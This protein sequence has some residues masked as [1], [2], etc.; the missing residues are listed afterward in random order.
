MKRAKAPM[1]A[2][3]A[4]AVAAALTLGGA[5]PALANTGVIEDPQ[6][7]SCINTEMLKRDANTPISNAEILGLTAAVNCGPRYAG[8]ETFEGLQGAPTQNA[9]FVGVTAT[10]LSPLAELPKLKGLVFTR[11]VVAG[12]NLDLQQLAGAGDTLTKLE[13]LVPGS[14][15][16]AADAPLTSITSLDAL[17]LLTTLT[18]N[19]A[20]M[21]ELEGLDALSHLKDV[22]LGGNALGNAQLAQLAGAPL[23][24]LY[25]KGNAANDFS[26]VAPGLAA[27]LTAQR[28]LSQEEVLVPAGAQ[29]VKANPKDRALGRAGA[30]A[31]LAGGAPDQGELVMSGF[32][33]A[34]DLTDTLWFA[35]PTDPYDAYASYEWSVSSATAVDSVSAFP[36][37]R[38][39]A[40]DDAELRA[41]AGEAVSLAP[42][43]F[44]YD[45][46]PQRQFDPVAYEIT[47]GALP[48]GVTLDASTGGLSG[49][50]AAAGTFAFTIAADDALGN[51]VAGEYVL[52][53]APAPS[54]DTPAASVSAGDVSVGDTLTVH[55]TG[56]APGE[57]VIATF[58][59]TGSAPATARADS[60]GRVSFDVSVTDAFAAGAHT[61]TLTGDTSGAAVASFNVR[62]GSAGGGNGGDDGGS[63]ETVPGPESPAG[64]ELATTGADIG[65]TA[66]V[67]LA[68]TLAAAGVGF[69]IRSRRRA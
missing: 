19:A 48:G 7:R 51:R 61:V 55:G 40:I 11:P 63:G 67:A 60:Q 41:V 62:A 4:V 46:Q 2:L 10:D 23:K 45:R 27:N 53:V 44:G 59:P 22:R 54:T 58:A 25:L 31:F 21:R 28:H 16:D 12:P 66:L 52:T 6:L 24:N 30:P 20:G 8:I 36:I 49:A 43:T 13:I 64:G 56:F 33:S 18:V 9:S 34:Q 32:V 68:L 29:A 39:S 26:W 15:P 37:V 14:A 65:M 3:G 5:A 57:T 17:P 47:A 50:P 69:V 42:V 1:N 38:V 35:E